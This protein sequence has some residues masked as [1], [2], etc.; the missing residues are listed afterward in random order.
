MRIKTVL[1]QALVYIRDILFVDLGICLLVAITFIF[2]RNFSFLG[3]SERIFWAG[4]GTTLIGGVVAFAATFSGRSFGIPTIIRRPKE[5]KNLLDH[6][7]EFREEVEK[8][9]DVSIRLFVIGLG[10]IAIS[11][12]I[13]VFMT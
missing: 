2:T 13:Q 3:L 8:R 6:F 7:M 12:L 10:C 4:L 5:A 9:N 1:I 11:A